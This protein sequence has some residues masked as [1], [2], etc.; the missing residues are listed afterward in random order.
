MGGL[1]TVGSKNRLTNIVKTSLK[2][3]R[4]NFQPLLFQS[5]YEG[6]VINQNPSH[7]LFEHYLQKNTTKPFIAKETGFLKSFLPNSI[8]LLN[9]SRL[10]FLWFSYFSYVV[11]IYFL[12]F[13]IVIV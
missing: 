5:V 8:L 3:I 4:L 6:I 7:V 1:L 13:K 9:T 10:L 11:S 12:S 2:I